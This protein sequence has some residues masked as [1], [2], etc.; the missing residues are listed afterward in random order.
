[1]KKSIIAT[2]LAAIAVIAL[3]LACG[4]A[5]TRGAQLLWSGSWMLVCFISGKASTKFIDDIDEEGK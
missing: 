1:M 3:F 5:E 4:E 2:I